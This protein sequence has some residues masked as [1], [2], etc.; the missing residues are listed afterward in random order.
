MSTSKDICAGARNLLINCAE[1]SGT[2]SLLI[3]SEDPDLG[4]YD[5]QTV[6]ALED[7]ARLLGITPTTL[8]V[9]APEN[10]RD[11]GLTQAMADHDCTIFMSRIG[12]QYRFAHPVPG[13]K[14]IMSY[15]RNANELASA[16]G[17]INHKAMLQLK[18]AVTGILLEAKNVRVTCPLGTDISG[19]TTDT[20]EETA[21]DIA[22]RRFP[23][24]V[25]Q[26]LDA[27]RMS[28][29]VAIA[30][31]LTPTG[32]KYYEPPSVPIHQTVI[33]DV[34]NGRITGL[35]GDV[36]DVDRIRNQYRRVA[37]LFDLDPDIVHS[38]HAGIHP[39][40]TY[41]DAAGD[42]PDRWSNST[43]T[44]PRTIHFHTC[45]NYPPGEI[46]WMVIDHTLRVDGKALWRGGR[47]CV[48]EFHPTARCLAEWPELR[49][50]FDSPSRTI[51]LPDLER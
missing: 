31:Y 51:G 6:A 32:S 9:G 44:N 40:S 25:P 48:E 35:T 50:L 26:P 23:M 42:N 45:G 5:G 2:E 33:A 1:L 13:K 29:Q 17:Q 14:T 30:R 18:K 38:F 39:G 27:S 4:W 36:D 46:C 7:A 37:G 8:H 3:I 21:A 16:Y 34:S 15:A 43:F 11:F 24:G 20:A 47:L 22:V 28:G 41:T 10:Y 12:D 19:D 49:P